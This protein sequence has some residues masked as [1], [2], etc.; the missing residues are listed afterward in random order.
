MLMSHGFRVGLFT[1]PHLVS[2]TERIRINN[3]QISEA[4]VIRLTETIKESA[5][6]ISARTGEPTFFEFVTAMAFLYLPG[7][8]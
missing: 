1:S 5:A 3:I 2:F 4:E 8:C 6:D 7:G